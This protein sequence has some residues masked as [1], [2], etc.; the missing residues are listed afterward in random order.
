MWICDCVR[1]YT[2]EH[3]FVYVYSQAGLPSISECTE[4]GTMYSQEGHILESCKFYSVSSTPEE[5]VNIA[6]VQI[7]CKQFPSFTGVPERRG[8]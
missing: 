6:T 3:V 7:K 1:V 2:C 5:A 8:W 4:K